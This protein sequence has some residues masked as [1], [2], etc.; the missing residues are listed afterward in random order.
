MRVASHALLARERQLEDAWCHL[1][2]TQWSRVANRTGEEVAVKAAL[3]N[4]VCGEHLYWSRCR[5]YPPIG[6][7]PEG[8][9]SSACRY[10][11]RRGLL[12]LHFFVQMFNELASMAYL[13]V[14][15]GSSVS[16]ST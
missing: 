8:S 14:G 7:Q 5:S 1:R 12:S 2:L 13:L 4:S 15:E 6:A 9:R 16:R 11:T 10:L 3:V